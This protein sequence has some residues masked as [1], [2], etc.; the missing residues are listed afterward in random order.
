[1]QVDLKKIKKNFQKS[2]DKYS[3]N[4]VVQRLMAEK[5]VKLVPNKKYSNFLEIGAGAGILTEQ[6]A[7]N[8]TYEFYVAND[9]I[10]KSELYVKKYIPNAKFYSGDF[11][12]IKFT[13][14]FDII[15]ANAVFQWFDNPEKVFKLCHSY[16]NSDGILAFS[17]FLP[18]NF[19][20]LKEITGL[21]LNYKTKDEILE[22]LNA[23]NFKTIALEEFDYNLRFD[24]P[25]KILAHM[26]DTGV[27]SLSSVKWEF[28]QVKEFCEKY[29]TLYPDLNLTYKSLLVVASK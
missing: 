21:S 28:K 20:E 15:S 25:L 3:S 17:T 4:A 19:K 18:G 24:N 22:I 10:E 2:L 7:E 14:K 27:N 26:K 5:L 8:L 11:R 29:Q 13:Q 16:L 12:K 23:N 9:I 1:M 6:I